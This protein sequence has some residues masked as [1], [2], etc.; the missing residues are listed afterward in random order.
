[1]GIVVSVRSLRAQL[2]VPPG[3]KIRA[4]ASGGGPET[5]ELLR[6]N[7]SYLKALARIETLEYSPDGVRPPHSATAVSGA[8]K[9][10]IPL[11]GVIDIA[12]ESERLQKELKK[13]QAELMKIELKVGNKDFLARAPEAE[14]VL[15][16]SQKET[17]LRHLSSLKDTLQA[18]S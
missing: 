17:A 18:L 9:L 3:L 12:K 14:V 15:A 5:E 8:L 13:V 16:C 11:E 2:N 4:V 1:M 10:F 7:E 6:K